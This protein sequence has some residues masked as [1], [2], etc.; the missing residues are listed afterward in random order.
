MRVQQEKY[1]DTIEFAFKDRSKLLHRALRESGCACGLMH[2]QEAMAKALGFANRHGM[3]QT[4]QGLRNALAADRNLLGPWA[5]INGAAVAAMCEPARLMRDF[6]LANPLEDE[7]RA[8][9]LGIGERTAKHLKVQPPQVLDAIA[10]AW[11]DARDWPHLVAR[12]PVNTPSTEPLVTFQV[13]VDERGRQVGWFEYTRQA[14]WLWDEVLG[15]HE[16]DLTYEPDIAHN[17]YMQAITLAQRHPELLV[18]WCRAAEIL[19]ASPQQSDMEWREAHRLYDKGILLTERLIPR[20]FRGSLPWGHMDNRPF[21]RALH[22]K[23]DLNLQS[24]W[25]DYYAYRTALKLKR[26]GGERYADLPAMAVLA[27]Q[28]LGDRPTTRRNIRRL[29]RSKTPSGLLHAGV[30]LMILRQPEGLAPVLEAVTRCPEFG[31][32][33]LNQRDVRPSARDTRRPESYVDPWEELLAAS[34]A[35]FAHQ[36]LLEWLQTVLSDRKLLTKQGA[37]DRM[38]GAEAVPNAWE[39]WHQEV[40]VFCAA[41]ARRLLELYPMPGTTAVPPS[42]R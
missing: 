42:G 17:E 3:Q 13:D 16:E 12:T 21:L 11:A 36:S 10:R 7:D 32:I 29:L 26:L 41:Q 27:S 2:V 33:L 20:G 4:S 9:L 40:P 19:L 35:L 23:M 28:R 6:E 5:T 15:S 22:R 25:G 8:L 18:A 24:K 31:A 30:A 1:L 38:L 34:M 39:N 37:L 14:H